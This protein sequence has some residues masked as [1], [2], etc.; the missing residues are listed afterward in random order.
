MPRNL[1]PPVHEAY[2]EWR[3]ATDHESKCFELLFHLIGSLFQTIIFV[4][5]DE[6]PVDGGNG[7]EHCVVN[8]IPV[9]K[10]QVPDPLLAVLVDQS[11]LGT[12]PQSGIENIHDTVD[13]MERKDVHD[14]VIL[15]PTPSIFHLG[16]HSL[17]GAM[18]MHYTLGV[19]GCTRGINDHGI[20]GSGQYLTMSRDQGFCL[21]VDI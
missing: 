11:A 17:Q 15:G 16:H 20:S 19:A 21:Q 7:H 6:L 18:S 13:V 12:G 10:Q 4:M 5:F 14:V 1:F 8:A 3:R 9:I 2:R